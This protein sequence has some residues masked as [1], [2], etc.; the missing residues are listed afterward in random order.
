MRR[1]A[2][3]V[4]VIT[5]VNATVCCQTNRL[6]PFNKVIAETYQYYRNDSIKVSVDYFA[7]YKFA[8]VI[9]TRDLRPFKRYLKPF[10]G[11]VFRR[12]NTLYGCTTDV[13][14]F[15]SA[16]WVLT[17]SPAMQDGLSAF[18]KIENYYE[19]IDTVSE[20]KQLCL[21]R[22]YSYG[23]NYIVFAA[24]TGLRYQSSIIRWNALKKLAQNE[25]GEIFKTIRLGYS[26]REKTPES[27][28]ILGWESFYEPDS[29]GNFLLPRLQMKKI[30]GNYQSPD[31]Q[32]SFNSA[33]LFFNCLLPDEKTANGKSVHP[34]ESQLP[35][36]LS[37]KL[38]IGQFKSKIAAVIMHKPGVAVTA[39]THLPK[40]KI[41]IGE[42][43]KTL[44]D[45][46]FT[47]M[48]VL[49]KNRMVD[50]GYPLVSS[51]DQLREPAMANVIKKAI[52][53][54]FT[55]ISDSSQRLPTQKTISIL[56][57]DSREEFPDDVALLQGGMLLIDQITLEDNI[58][59][60]AAPFR[61]SS[62]ND[63]KMLVRNS[64]QFATQIISED[65]VQRLNAAIPKEAF[66]TG[67]PCALLV[68]DQ[69]ELV[70]YNEV[71]LPVSTR[72]LL[73]GQNTIDLMFPRGT[74]E[75]ITKDKYNE[76]TYRTTV[77]VR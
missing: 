45:N 13:P 17:N 50:L 42:L 57:F 67:Q 3:Y 34:T 63:G 37:E 69:K 18:S 2:L 31:E 64:M 71:T 28:F 76:V 73:P 60:T 70:K 21:Q 72:L 77:I 53:E 12:S 51:A 32:R 41:M 40:H 16:A 30:Q 58:I 26:Y 43:L 8:P 54:G 6:L 33:S 22:I 15:R 20:Q 9:K 39:L 49:H 47:G 14:Y 38:S 1:I 48:S 24:L 25:F 65:S 35:A 29:A 7:D 46:G 75:L 36:T 56:L 66:G 44:H 23:K 5:V 62:S 27:P 4:F 61:I 10:F 68:F 19:R 11:N 52:K 74:Y 55:L 59:D